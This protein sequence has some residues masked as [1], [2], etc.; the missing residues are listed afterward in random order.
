ML[1]KT[2]TLPGWG[3][4]ILDYSLPEGDLVDDVGAQADAWAKTHAH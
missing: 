3:V 2:Q 1:D 4:H